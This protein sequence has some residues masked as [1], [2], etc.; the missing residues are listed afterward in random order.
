MPATLYIFV[1]FTTA[2]KNLTHIATLVVALCIALC[3][4]SLPVFANQTIEAEV[5]RQYSAECSFNQTK[6][7]N[8]LEVTIFAENKTLQTISALNNESHINFQPKSRVWISKEADGNYYV[9]LPKRTDQLL[10][11]AV[12]FVVS[13]FVLIGKKGLRAIGTLFGT[14]VVILWGCLPLL[15]NFPGY[16]IPIGLATVMLILT[17]NILFGQGFHKN[18][19]ISLIGAA[20]T[21]VIVGVLTSIFTGWTLTTGLGSENSL[22]LRSDVA[23]TA[24][25]PV[26]IFFVGTMIGI[27]GAVDDVTNA[28][29]IIVDETADKTVGFWANYHRAM[30][31]GSSHIVSM[32]NTLFLAYLGV[33]LTT[34]LLFQTD[35]LSQTDT[36]FILSRDDFSE[37]IVRTLLAS[38]AVIFA[39]PITTILAIWAKLNHKNT[40]D[41][42]SVDTP[43]SLVNL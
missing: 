35:A 31:L 11:I 41:K 40:D 22:F 32:V 17:M 36:F 38:F 29:A 39:I 1:L 37:E 28:Q 15:V 7:C 9:Q 34:V 5:V 8:Y 23:T 19:Y 27:A 10:W 14:S 6:T 3:F 25:N 24:L 2:R 20:I 42:K 16:F 4:V 21:L 12:L 18:S 26:H 43:T 33:S 13:T 30:K